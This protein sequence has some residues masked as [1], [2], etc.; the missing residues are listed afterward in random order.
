MSAFLAE[1]RR[2]I[3]A[4]APIHFATQYSLS[5]GEKYPNYIDKINEFY[6]KKKQKK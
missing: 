3:Q 1:M 4:K 2:S 5:T 6:F